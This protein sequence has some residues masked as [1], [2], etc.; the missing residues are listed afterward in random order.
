MVPLSYRYKLKV[1]TLVYKGLNSL[2]PSYISSMLN[3]YEPKTSM[4]LR[5]VEAKHLEVPF[6]RSSVYKRAFS[7]N[8]PKLYNELP[9]HIRESN[10]Y[11]WHL[12]NQLAIRI[13]I[14]LTL[15]Q[16]YSLMSIL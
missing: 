16:F 6:T 4:C 15:I 5:S 13:F 8:G 14:S 10:V 3:Q 7:V 11:S 9:L 2:A 12:L 1:V